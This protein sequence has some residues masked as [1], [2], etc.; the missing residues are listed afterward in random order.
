MRNQV[1]KMY[2]SSAHWKTTSS[3]YGSF[4]SSG[5]STSST[6]A[7]RHYGSPTATNHYSS[8]SSSGNHFSSSSSSSNASPGTRT[9]R[10]LPAVPTS[11]G[12]SSS[13]RPPPVGSSSGQDNGTTTTRVRR[14]TTGST[15]IGGSPT[16]KTSIL[17]GDHNIT[18]PIGSINGT[19]R[20]SPSSTRGFGGIS[21][22]NGVVE[23][24]TASISPSA[25]LG[26][27]KSF[28]DL[29]DRFGDKLRINDEGYQRTAKASE[30]VR[31]GNLSGGV[32]GGVN[33]SGITSGLA[34]LRRDSSSDYEGNNESNGYLESSSLK[35]G[36]NAAAASTVTSTV[37]CS[38]QRDARSL[39]RSV[40]KEADS[41][42]NG[43][44][45][46]SSAANNSTNNCVSSTS[47]HSS[48]H[49]LENS[50]LKGLRNLGNTCFMNSV[51]QCLSNTRPLL[52]FALN[53][54]FA[55]QVNKTTSSMKGQLM[56][57][58]AHLLQDLWKSSSSENYISPSA[59]KSAVAK[60]APRF[61]GYAQQDAQEFLRYLLQGLAE[62]V[63]RV[64]SKPK[65][66][67]INDEEEDK[68]SDLEKAALS[69]KR[70]LR[71]EDSRIGEIF[72]G[73]LKS[74]LKCTTCS[75]ASVT[76]DP[77][78]DLSLPLPK[79][80]G[81]G[82]ATPL[83][84]CMSLF[85]KEEI[86]DGDER[87]K[88]SRCKQRRRC[89]KSFS[90]QRFPRIL[91]LHLKRFAGSSFRAKLSTLVDF[92]Q[93]LDLSEFAADSSPA[94][95]SSSSPAAAAAASS[96]PSTATTT[97]STTSSTKPVY[98]LYA[99]SNH[100]GSTHS[101]HYTAYCKHPYS[102]QWNYYNDSRVSKHSK[103]GVCSAEGYVLFYELAGG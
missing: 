51:I 75:Y 50:G 21:D 88:C 59:F 6:S 94:A 90:I 96:G 76:F 49:P 61:T 44:S 83:R 101:G 27:T 34:S 68:L 70:Y 22:S 57:A 95:N 82:S 3:R 71:F 36:V 1:P 28:S 60:F 29:T 26:R 37:R 2:E 33:V 73:Q 66:L 65:P 64:T 102:S 98:H 8:S 100:S 52:E 25:V 47:N 77:F 62:D 16:A 9:A 12:A 7:S 10:F 93:A 4:H 103:S 46:A 67:I 43:G 86:L 15:D 19:S 91:V 31:G 63:N 89:T 79:T 58:F 56:I 18:K 69:W 41:I 38:P 13:S 32:S 30:S 48:N 97:S 23:S 54:N 45:K 84:S 20:F 99:V 74:T 14:T 80:L 42:V 85:T 53:D 11:A 72:V 17:R 81:G 40:S 78:W 35:R 5:V 39:G 87:P 92:P 55:N 24:T